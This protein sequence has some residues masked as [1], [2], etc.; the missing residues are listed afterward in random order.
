M[1]QLEGTLRVKSIT[2]SWQNCSLPSRTASPNA[3]GL[4]GKVLVVGRS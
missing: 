1:K 3:L 2:S 4:P